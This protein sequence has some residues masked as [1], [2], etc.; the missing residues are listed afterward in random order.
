MSELLDGY[1]AIVGRLLD[2]PAHRLVDQRRA[3]CT[4]CPMTPP[5]D[6]DPTG[7][8][9]FLPV[10]RCCTF[11][12]DL[13][14][15]LVGAGLDSQV[16]PRLRERLENPDGRLP[17]G[18]SCRARRRRAYLKGASTRFGRDASLACP[19]VRGDGGGCGIYRWRAATCRAW[20]CRY[21]AGLAGFLAWKEL[22]SLLEAA[23]SRLARACARALP[24]PRFWEGRSAWEAYYRGTAATVEVLP[25][26]EVEALKHALEPQ[27][28][29]TLRA[30]FRQDE[31]TPAFL[32]THPHRVEP[33]R[34]GIWRLQGYSPW[35]RV[36]APAEILDLLRMLSR[37]GA[38]RDATAAI[39]QRTGQE[40]EPA[41][42]RALWQHR[43]LGPQPP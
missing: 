21:D 43:I 32:W 38:W 24:S 14:N 6:H 41:L 37:G 18:L 27:R 3:P 17:E 1:P 31:S 23:E 4:A 30:L 33:C 42:V 29:R 9:S 16:A 35:D 40:L 34:D 19:F 10:V 11:E 28:A 39:A 22:R 15:Y 25:E 12:P 26:Q 5:E 8:R 13:P 20:Y 36:E 2:L 7:E